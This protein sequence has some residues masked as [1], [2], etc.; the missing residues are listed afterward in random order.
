MKHITIKTLE[1]ISLSNDLYERY[2]S[3]CKN[4]KINH[5]TYDDWNKDMSHTLNHIKHWKLNKNTDLM[6]NYAEQFYS[7]YPVYFFKTLSKF[8]YFLRQDYMNIF[9]QILEKDEPILPLNYLFKL[10]NQLNL[11]PKQNINLIVSDGLGNRL[12]QIAAMYS[13]AKQNKY[14]LS[15]YILP[16]KHTKQKYSHILEK[17]IVIDKKNKTIPLLRE[18]SNCIFDKDI[19][20]MNNILKHKQVN[21][22]GFFQCSS[23]FNSYKA[24]ILNLFEI[25]VYLD[26]YIDCVYPLVNDSWFLHVRL[27][28]FVDKYNKHKHFIDLTKYYENHLQ[29]VSKDDNIYL[30]SDDTYTN[31]LTYYPF[32]SNYSNITYVDIKN[33][34]IAFYMMI[35][36][37]KGGICA[38]STFSWWAGY[39]NK[40]ENKT[41]HLPNKMINKFVGKFNL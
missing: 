11:E 24:D 29:S 21:V 31:I 16:N 18:R 1:F 26:F 7:N 14:S 34:L 2:L 9:L 25:P 30:F 12:F 37:R 41:I 39:L 23:Y 40:N 20:L 8:S 22:S 10:Y 4:L 17:F 19:D 32:L 38:N 36:C 28:D 13:F 33:E 27:T 3:Q 6:V 15:L 5:L 35:K